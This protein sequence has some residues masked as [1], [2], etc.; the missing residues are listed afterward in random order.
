MSN[1]D[2]QRFPFVPKS[3]AF[4]R[5]GQC[6]A[7]PLADGRYGCGY[8][9]AVY[10]SERRMFLAGLTNWFGEKLPVP[11][12]L[13]GHFVIEQAMA[14]IKTITENGRQILG[15][16]DTP[17]K[18]VAKQCDPYTTWGYK[19]ITLLAERHAKT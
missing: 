11:A 15:C 4:L 19:V 10:P 3:T 9:V 12:D 13:A 7:V 2:E 1:A 18:V 5:E 14:H 6:W 17:L 16:C 8:I